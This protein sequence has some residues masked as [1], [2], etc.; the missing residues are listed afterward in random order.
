M[1]YDMSA[2]DIDRTFDV[3]VHIVLYIDGKQIIDAVFNQDI[4]SADYFKKDIIN[5]INAYR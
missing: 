4:E 1:A 3:D 5:I 2:G